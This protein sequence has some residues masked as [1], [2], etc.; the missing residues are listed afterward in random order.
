VADSR[1]QPASPTC[2]PKPEGRRW[3][4]NARRLG[5]ESEAVVHLDELFR[6][7]KRVMGDAAA[8]ED[9]VQD[10]CLRAWQAFDRF[11]SGTNCRAWLYKILFRTIGSRRRELQRELAMFDDQLFD[12][13]RFPS[14]TPANP[15][16]TH[17]IQKA[18]DE[19]PIA[20]ATVIQ[21]VDVEGLSYKEVSEALEVP[22]G[23]VMSRL[24]RG[25]RQLRQRLAPRPA[26]TWGN[27]ERL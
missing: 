25:R 23:T 3:K 16:T 7:A 8:A 6:V 4:R 27:K 18:F 26:L 5:F 1:D 10:T 13:S 17:Q 14:S 19:L 2:P 11:E 20:F 22:V 24:H 21:L 9:V 15:F 12:E